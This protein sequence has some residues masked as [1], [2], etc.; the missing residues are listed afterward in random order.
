ME[1]N[2]TSS[3]GL[4][5]L[6]FVF[7]PWLH[8]CISPLAEKWLA[9][10]DEKAMSLHGKTLERITWHRNPGEEEMLYMLR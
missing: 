9:Y 3:F 1:A 4:A 10:N 5:L 6:T 2:G 8:G 7:I